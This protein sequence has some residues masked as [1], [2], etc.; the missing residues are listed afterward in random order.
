MKPDLRMDPNSWNWNSFVPRSC[1]SKTECVATPIAAPQ[2]KTLGTFSCWIEL[3]LEC[4]FPVYFTPL[5]DREPIQQARRQWEWRARHQRNT[6]ASIREWCKIA[7]MTRC[8]LTFQFHLPTAC[9]NISVLQVDLYV[10]ITSK[11]GHNFLLQVF[12]W[13]AY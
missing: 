3:F 10:G 4:F 7:I 12:C 5:K 6:V 13:K 9:T 1:A 11:G 8:N 2:Q